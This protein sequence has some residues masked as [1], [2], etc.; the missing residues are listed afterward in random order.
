MDQI[1]IKH[2]KE[3]VEKIKLLSDIKLDCLGIFELRYYDLIVIIVKK[4]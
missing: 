4:T 2:G 3:V 1:D